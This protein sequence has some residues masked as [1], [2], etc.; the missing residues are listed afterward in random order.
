MTLAS[1]S[2]ATDTIK[3]NRLHDTDTGSP[4]VQIAL[5]TKRLE[6]VSDHSKKF[7]ND[8]HA[9]R[10]LLQ[11]VSRR[12]NLLAYLHKEDVGRYKAVLERF[13]LRK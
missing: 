7:P 11:I 12:K 13:G 5:L 2:D 9:R 3:N 6:V 1:S 4:E 10:G 8:K